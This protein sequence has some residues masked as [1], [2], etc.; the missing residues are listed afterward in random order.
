MSDMDEYGIYDFDYIKPSDLLFDEYLI[1]QAEQ[2]EYL[3]EK[4][5]VLKVRATPEPSPM[6]ILPKML[7]YCVA[8]E[9]AEMAFCPTEFNISTSAELTAVLNRFWITIGRVRLIM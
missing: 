1:N 6:K 7:E 3:A 4:Y 9:T 5:N 8:R 2:V